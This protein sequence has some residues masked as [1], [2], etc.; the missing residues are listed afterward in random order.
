MMSRFLLRGSFL[1]IG[2][3]VMLAG[4]GATAPTGDLDSLTEDSNANGFFDVTPPDG[5]DFLTL[6]NVKVR[7]VNT[8]ATDD[9]GGIAAQYGV[10]PS[11]LSLVDIVATIDINLD[12]GDGI[13]DSLVQSESI[14]PFDRKFEIACPD[15]VAV[16]VAVTANVPIVGTQSITNF[17]VD[18]SQG[19]EYDCG[20]TIE[21]RVFINDNGNPDVTV[22]VV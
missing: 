16:D 11:L 19:A 5:V 2:L 20:Q 17:N 21:V 1:A 7:I 12:Y 6:D 4:C 13:S 3:A 8:V 9:L 18:L 10:D 22:N 14:E 15:N